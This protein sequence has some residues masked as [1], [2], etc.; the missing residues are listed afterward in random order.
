MNTLYPYHNT[1]KLDTRFI[2]QNIST[3]TVSYN[4]KGLISVPGYFLQLSDF[5]KYS[6]ICSFIIKCI[7]AYIIPLTQHIKIRHSF[8]T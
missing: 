4:V 3:G 2:T 6:L 8:R 1:K 7:D 5:E